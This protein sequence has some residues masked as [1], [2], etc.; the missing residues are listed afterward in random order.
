[1]FIGIK[2]NFIYIIN[3]NENMF[4]TREELKKWI[5]D[6]IT[7]NGKKSLHIAINNS[8]KIKE[9]LINFTNFLPIETK[10]NQRCYHLINDIFEIPYCKECKKEKVNFNNRNKDWKYLDF[11]SQ[12]CGRINKDTISK[13]KETHIKR[14]GAD[15]I[16]KTE[17]FHELMIKINNERYGLD[18]YQ[19]SD[20]FKDK[21][22]ETCL[23][24]YGFESFT[25]TEEFKNKLSKTFMDKYGVDW[26]AKSLEFREKF[27]QKS[28]E[29]YGTEHP[30]LNS[31]IKNRV[32]K[33]IKN[34]YGK[35]W[36]I[37][38][39][40]FKE[41]CFKFKDNKYGHPIGYKLKEYKLPSGKSIKIQGYENFA[42]DILLKRYREEDLS[43]TYSEIREEIGMINYL[44]NDKEKIYL[45][46]IYIIPENKIIE[47][48][49]DYT[50]NLSLEQN[51]LKKEA[52]LSSG[53]LFE[54]WILDKKG[55]LLE[56]K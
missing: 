52:C 7:K 49:S 50:Y 26:Y 51:L 54:F 29:K 2:P 23:K 30:M 45:P 32:S 14:F 22:R 35:D 18:W 37:L 48:K 9:D 56:I 38:T 10:L 4:N 46:D 47:V 40:E 19:Q 33:T 16:S 39:N 42:L 34:K 44:M 6:Y 55:S 27:R 43:I 31:E 12:R 17:Y 15:N 11:C 20:D 3:I 25:K 53:I 41:Y 24:K 21:S 36:Y 1:M 28:L 13:F 8:K 5:N